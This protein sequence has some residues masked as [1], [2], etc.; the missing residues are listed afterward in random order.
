V[1]I[2]TIVDE[3]TRAVAWVAREGAAHGAI[4]DRIVV[5]GHSAGGH[6]VAMLYATD[7]ARHGFAR[8]PFLGGV[9]LSGVHDLEPMVQFS[10]NA[11]LKLDAREA[12]RLSPVNLASRARA[13]LVLAA[14]ADENLR[15]RPPDATIV[16]RLARKSPCGRART[17][18]DS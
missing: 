1:S 14:G 17:A 5:G 18:A 13:P 7:W 6:L 11:D 3:A 12:A 9:S 15:I 4:P 2:A 16:G 10:Y 8:E